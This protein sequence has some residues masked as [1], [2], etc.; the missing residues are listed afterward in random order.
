MGDW[1][2]VHDGRSRRGRWDTEDHPDIHPGRNGIDGS[3]DF[4]FAHVLTALERRG[5]LMGGPHNDV[6]CAVADA[7]DD[8]A[9]RGGSHSLNFV[10]SNREVVYAFRLGRPLYQLARNPIIGMA[11][12]VAFASEPLTD[13]PWTPIPDGT[14]V[15][16]VDRAEPPIR[17]TVCPHVPA[18]G[19]VH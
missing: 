2:F 7:V 13:E 17:I 15:R 16:A 1:L 3:S 18:R 10:L 19:W 14:L 4:L 8:L 12:H 11:R 6:D 9:A 5:V